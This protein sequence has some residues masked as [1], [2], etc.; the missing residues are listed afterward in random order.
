M[1]PL[2]S[3][4]LHVCLGWTVLVRGFDESIWSTL[5]ATVGGRLHQAKPFSL[6]CFSI[7][8]GEPL[9]PNAT[10]CAQIQ[11]NYTSSSLRTQFYN[12]FMNN[13]D[14]MCA[15]NSTDQCLLNSALPTDPTAFTNV[16]CNQG[17]VSKYYIEVQTTDDIVAAFDFS[18]REGV[19]L[20]IKNSGHDYQ[21]R[22]SR[23]GSLALWIRNLSGISRDE[24]FIPAGCTGVASRDSIITGAGANFDEVY[25]FADQEGVTFIGGYASTIGTSGGWVQGGG[26]SVLSVVYGLGIDRVLE[27]EIVT[28]DGVLRTA[29]A[30]TNPD[31]FW[32]LRGG[33]G[34]TFGVVVSATHAVEPAISLSVAYIKYVQTTANVNTWF[35]ILI[36]NSLPWANGG[37]GGHY[38]ANNLI[39]VTPLLNVSSATDSMAAASDFAL[40]NNGTVTIETLPSWYAFYAKYVV[41]NIAPVASPRILATRLIPASLFTT[42]KGRS[43]LLSFLQSI[44]A[45]GLSPYIPSTTP[46]LYPWDPTSTSATPAWRDAIWHLGFGA[47]WTY[48][49][50]FEQREASILVQDKLL[51]EIT[52]LAPDSGAYGNEAFPWTRDWQKDW[53]GEN[54]G[55]LVEVKGKYDPDGLLNCW[56]CVGFEE[57]S[58]GEEFGCFQGL[59]PG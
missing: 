27:F 55:R 6:P 37:W 51:Q 30:C 12:G 43:Q 26:H 18:R 3:A 46:F 10:A 44:V 14:E 40:A 15:T 32:A 22:S 35:E 57:E 2:L 16:S 11:K 59:S 48:N 54:Y 56:K 25:Q 19:K 53:W 58:A 1:R 20:S 21:G 13:Q 5:N 29:N 8:E 31:L 36:N 47:A 28:P 42:D 34:G 17:S 23:K 50:S 7:Y 24:N 33:G 38:Q 39:C 49:S 52:E 4:L 45:A 41:P 9:T